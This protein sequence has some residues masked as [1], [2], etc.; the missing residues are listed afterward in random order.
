MHGINGCLGY[1]IH[2]I[3]KFPVVAVFASV[4]FCITYAGLFTKDYQPLI[5]QGDIPRHAMDIE[6]LKEPLENSAKKGPGLF[7]DRA[8]DYAENAVDTT[9]IFVENGYKMAASWLYRQP[10]AQAAIKS[11]GL[12][13]LKLEEIK[14]QLSSPKEEEEDRKEIDPSQ[15]YVLLS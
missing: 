2:V 8:T 10:L 5:L 4:F 15:K 6:Q 1:L 9:I 11:Y 12:F 7:I 14:E 3:M 13:L